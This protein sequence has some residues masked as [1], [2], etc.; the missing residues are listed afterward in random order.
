MAGVISLPLLKFSLAT[1][2]ATAQ[3]YTW[4]HTMQDLTVVFD[5]FYSMEA[6]RNSRDLKIMRVIQGTQVLV[7]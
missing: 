3:C 7:C 4:K 6:E 1:D 2:V 5:S